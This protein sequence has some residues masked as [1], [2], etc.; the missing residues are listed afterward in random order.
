MAQYPGSIPYTGYVAPADT[1]DTYPVTHEEFNYGGYRTVVNSTD[2]LAITMARRKEGMLVKQLDNASYW[3][4]SGGVLDANWS[5]VFFAMLPNNTTT[6][7]I[8]VTN[9]VV[10]YLATDGSGTRYLRED[11]TWQTSTGG[12]SGSGTIDNLPKFTS[13]SG[14]G[15][16]KFTDDGTTPK[17]NTNTIWHAGN[18]GAGSTLDADTID[19]IESARIIY[20]QNNIGYN[21]IS[22]LDCDN[23]AKAG[24]YTLYATAHAPFIGDGGLINIPSWAGDNGTDRHNFQLAAELGVD[25]Y[26]AR[27]TNAAGTGLWAK[28]YHDKNINLS[29]VDFLAKDLTV[30][31]AKIGSLSGYLKATLGVVGAV[32]SIPESDI[33]P[34]AYATL[35][36]TSN[37]TT[38]DCSTGLNKRVTISANLALTITNLV[39]GM[40]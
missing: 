11:F 26:Y 20:G 14:M 23:V 34:T 6:G 31:T 1:T 12:I 37:A 40:S 16:S 7:I 38:W 19:G 9:G 4:L 22:T 18:D 8:K 39:D 33:T 10:S 29:T 5:Q 13:G 25:N 32:S 21:N 35:A 36:V 2:R 15:D 28:L 30:T 27:S 3:T 24:F 17:Y